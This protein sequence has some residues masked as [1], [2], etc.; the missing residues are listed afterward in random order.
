MSFNP[1]AG[2][3]FRCPRYW[4]Y[5]C[6]P[7]IGNGAAGACPA[8]SE[9]AGALPAAAVETGG[10]SSKPG[11]ALP[12]AAVE[13]AGA[14]SKPGGALPAAAVETGG[15][16][17]KPAGALPATAVETGKASSKGGRSS[18]ADS[19][20]QKIGG[21]NFGAFVFSP[22]WALFNL[23]IWLSVP[24]ILLSSLGP[25]ILFVMKST[26][27][28]KLKVVFY[29]CLGHRSM[30]DLFDFAGVFLFMWWSYA[31]IAILLF[32]KGND[33]AWKYP[34]GKLGS[35]DG[36]IKAQRIWKIFAFF[37]FIP[38]IIFMWLVSLVYVFF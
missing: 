26:Y 1:S 27:Y 11:G 6:S 32:F 2:T 29:E 37:L 17:S 34:V 10:A 9:P 12:A 24:F 31:I 5:N 38:K 15:A 36:Y 25:F 21:C 3:D 23:K 4:P 14:S 33:W 13:T 22:L 18:S 20:G 16:S 19:S 30:S 35:V 7:Y 8:S 28:P